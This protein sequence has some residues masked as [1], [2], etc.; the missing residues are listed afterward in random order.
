MEAWLETDLLTW[1]QK[2]I[3]PV[4]IEIADRCGEFDGQS[5]LQGTPLNTADGLIAATAVE[6]GLTLVTRNTKHFARLRI[7]VSSPWDS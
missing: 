3:L 4:T 2:R 5:H 6:H 1:F 7:V